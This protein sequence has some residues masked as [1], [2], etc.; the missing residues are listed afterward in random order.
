MYEKHE[1]HD[2]SEKER[3]AKKASK[4]ELV[5][6]EIL[7]IEDVPMTGRRF[8]LLILLLLFWFPLLDIW[9]R[10]CL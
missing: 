10:G 1:K 2:G 9:L 4:P 6:L 7:Y 5:A 3:T 8:G